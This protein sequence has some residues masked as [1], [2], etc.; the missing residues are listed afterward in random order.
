V[1]IGGFIVGAVISYLTTGTSGL[2][3]PSTWA[4]VRLLLAY[5]LLSAITLTSVGIITFLAYL[6]YRNQQLLL[7]E[8]NYSIADVS[9]NLNTGTG[10]GASS[11]DIR[12]NIPYKRNIFFTGRETILT[13][14]YDILNAETSTVS[15]L[16]LCGLGGIGKTQIAI[17]YAYCF[18]HDYQAIFWV[19]AN[20][21]DTLISDFVSIAE[22]LQLSI[23]DAAD[24]NL[25]VE[26]VNLWLKIN[27]RWLL[28]FDNANDLREVSNFV[29][30]TSHGHT[31]LT[32]H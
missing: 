1:I 4:I 2:A 31:L 21:H 11:V 19:R 24:Q 22:L 26:A 5:P 3:N 18:Q 17:E 23:K 7:K 10:K 9:K 8:T 27:S 15:I 25:T 28:V 14:I 32:T 6:A 29:P 30:T 16:A 13:K 20:S 12:N